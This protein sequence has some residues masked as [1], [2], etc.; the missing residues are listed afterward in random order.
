M[1]NIVNFEHNK[2]T[3][4]NWQLLKNESWCVL[5]R[6]GSG[7]Q[8]INQLLSGTLEPTSFE[9][10]QSPDKDKVGIISFEMQQDTYEHT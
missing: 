1:I 9:Q 8:Y 10:L 7:K 2:L 4:K 6:N 3:I 5:G